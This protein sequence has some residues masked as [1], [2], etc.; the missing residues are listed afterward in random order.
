MCWSALA[1]VAF[2]C[3]IQRAPKGQSRSPDRVIYVTSQDLPGACYHELGGLKVDES[4]ASVAID[5]DNSE[6]AEQLKTLCLRSSNSGFLTHP[7]RRIDSYRRTVFGAG[8]NSEESL[9][10]FAVLGTGRSGERTL[11]PESLRPARAHDTSANA[12]RHQTTSDIAA[13]W[14]RALTDFAE[15]RSMIHSYQRRKRPTTA[16][17][18]DEVALPRNGEACHR[19]RLSPTGNETVTSA[20]MAENSGP[21]S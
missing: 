15:E 21:S 14:L 5:P 2:A 16:R 19:S 17:P 13:R 6:A 8:Q 7:G 18:A 12:S 3:A 10:S 9:L 20:S 1:T 4:F 11:R